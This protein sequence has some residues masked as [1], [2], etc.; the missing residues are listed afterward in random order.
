MF[1]LLPKSNKEL[2]RREY[3]MR[4]AVVSLWLLCGALVIASLLLLPSLFLSSAL[5]KAATLRFDAL[6]R[7]TDGEEAAALDALL[8]GTAARA[9]LLKGGSPNVLLH[10]LLML[11]ASITTDRI[12]LAGISFG[13]LSEG[14]RDITLTG[15]A[16]DR[17]GLLSFVRA[18]EKTD[19][20]ER[21]ETPISNFA[22]DTDINF[23]VRLRGAF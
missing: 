14:K 6:S 10:E 13:A 4:L 18:L 21:V 15:I 11:I 3:H 17:A 19:V 8:A 1:N 12:S 5:E 22:K 7:G 2:I 16:R 20:F 23:D 9:A